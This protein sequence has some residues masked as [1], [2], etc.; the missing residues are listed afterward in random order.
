MRFL[1]TIA[2]CCLLCTS[3]RAQTAPP[4]PIAPVDPATLP[5]H[6][7]HEGLLIAA[8]PYSDAARARERF[9]KDNPVD[10]GLL[11]VELFLKNETA[12][13]MRIRLETIRLDIAPPGEPRQKIQAITADEAAVRIVYPAGTPDPEAK[14][15]RLPSPIPLP[16]HD[17]KS[18]KVAARL[19]PLALDADVIPPLATLHGFVFFDVSHDFVLV[20]HASV[21]VPDV[22]V[23][24]GNHALTYFELDLGAFVKH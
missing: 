23:I 3:V 8:D 19:R 14:R 20:A 10:A 24:P 11:P 17:K 1:L 4:A 15:A 6:D 12:Q 18:D 5:A 2:A 7:R 22:I 16:H 9:G 13:P 21:Y